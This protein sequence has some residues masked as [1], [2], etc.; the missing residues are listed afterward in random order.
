MILLATGLGV[1]SLRQQR[2]VCSTKHILNIF[3]E[4]CRSRVVVN[5]V[6]PLNLSVFYLVPGKKEPDD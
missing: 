6:E 4:N 1:F 2:S 5:N 3:A